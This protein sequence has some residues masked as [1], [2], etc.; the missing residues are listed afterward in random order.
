MTNSQF[1]RQMATEGIEPDFDECDH[2]LDA[3]KCDGYGN[4]G[5]SIELIGGSRHVAPAGKGPRSDATGTGWGLPAE[6]DAP[7]DWEGVSTEW[8]A[9]VWRR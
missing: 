7:E 1:Q 6:Y 3:A 4:T 8:R 9:C 5:A 2:G